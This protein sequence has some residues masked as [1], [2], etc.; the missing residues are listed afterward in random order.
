MTGRHRFTLELDGEGSGASSTGDQQGCDRLARCRGIHGDRFCFERALDQHREM[1]G[2]DAVGD[3]HAGLFQGI[4][5]DL[6]RATT[7]VGITVNHHR[8]VP[9]ARQPH[10]DT[11]RGPRVAGMKHRSRWPPV[12]WLSPVNLP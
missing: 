4:Q 1:F 8:D 12:L 7:K 10:Q 11:K 2:S 3:G 5:H 6:E 9:P